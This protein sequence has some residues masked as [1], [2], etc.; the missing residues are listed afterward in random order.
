VMGTTS[1]DVWARSCSSGGGR[2][3]R[4]SERLRPSARI[5]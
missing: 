5:H 1:C 4:G 2:R 3:R